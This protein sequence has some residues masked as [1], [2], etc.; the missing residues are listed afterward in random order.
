MVWVD[1]G[2]LWRGQVEK[3]IKVAKI[4]EFG[5]WIRRG[6]EEAHQSCSSFIEVVIFAPQ[7]MDLLRLNSFQGL[8]MFLSQIFTQ[9]TQERSIG[10]ATIGKCGER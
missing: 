4:V 5:I 3:L 8:E 9:T 2:L 6:G 10:F 7:P 1:K